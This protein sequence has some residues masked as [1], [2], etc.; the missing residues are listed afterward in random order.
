M[1]AGS[2]RSARAVPEWL[3][4]LAPHLAGTERER[5]AEAWAECR[6]DFFR[7]AQV[8]VHQASAG[9]NCDLL[10][11]ENHEILPARYSLDESALSLCVEAEVASKSPSARVPERLQHHCRLAEVRNIWVCSDSELARRACEGARHTAQAAE[12]RVLLI[13]ALS[14]PVAIMEMS[15]EAMDVFLDGMAVLIAA[16]RLRSEPEVACRRWNTGPPPPEACLRPLGKSLRSTHLAGPICSWLAQVGEDVLLDC[17]KDGK[18]VP[19]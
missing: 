9:V 14:G 18:V 3:A 17:V 7:R 12:A 4:D 6:D 1:E 2:P 8:F 19:V 16:Q 11:Q 5:A 13:D 10:D 15:E